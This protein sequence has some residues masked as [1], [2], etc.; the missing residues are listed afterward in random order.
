MLTEIRL[1]APDGKIASGYFKN[2]ENLILELRKYPGYGVYYTINRINDDCYGRAQLEHFITKPKNTTTDN[3]IKYREEVV[4]DLDPVRCA[5]SNSTDEELEYTKKKTNEIYQFLRDNGFYA[6]IVCLSGNGTHIKIRCA[7]KNEEQNT[8]LVSKF[9]MTMDMLFSDDRV[10]VDVTLKNSARILKTPG[11]WSVKGNDDPHSDRPRRMARYVK[12][13]DDWYENV[14]QNEYFQKIADMY[15]EPEQPSQSNNYSPSKFNIDE[16]LSK[17]GIEVFKDIHTPSGRKILLKNCVF[18]P[19]HK[20]GEACIFVNNSG[21]LAYFCYHNSCS[22][23]TWRDVRLKYEPDAYT[24]KEVAEYH[25]RM[26]YYGKYVREP[27][28]PME[29]SDVYGKKWKTAKDIKRVDV[30]AIPVVN[31]GFLEIDKYTWG[32]FMG[33][34]TIVSGTSGS[35]KSSYINCLI[36]N[37]VERNVKVG[38]VTCELQDFRLMSW[39]YQTIAGKNYVKKKEGY[40]NWYYAPFNICDRIDEWLS[41]RFYVYNNDYGNNFFQIFNDVQE[42][43]ETKYV[44]VVVIDNLACLDLSEYDGKDLEKQTKLI[45]DLKNYA[46]QK[47]VHIVLVAH[48]KKLGQELNRKE[49]VS[50]SNNLTN[51]ADV[52]LIVNRKSIDYQ[53]RL[54]EFMG[55]DKAQKFEEFDSVIEISKSRMSGQMDKFCGLF[56]EIESRRLKN[57]KAEHINYGWCAEPVQSTMYSAESYTAPAQPAMVAAPALQPVVT[58][59]QEQTEYSQMPFAP[60]GDGEEC[61]F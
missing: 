46:K 40:E 25:Q 1:I 3:D 21:A 56:F 34:V 52:V 49:S 9:L 31:T 42:L 22:H 39:L 43:V 23:Y 20:N 12:I 58:I 57:S 10:N 33:D 14:N 26:Q 24:R 48:P 5:G 50:G 61:P 54:V 51:L 47:N 55:L 27:F 8:Q 17:H 37:L 38:L 35:G 28:K 59:E 29:E 11:S 36:A 60:A 4:L 7:M 13:P 44:S 16:F 30:S 32:M 19:E 2:I 45:S 18:N 53:K 15:P 41:D 6:P